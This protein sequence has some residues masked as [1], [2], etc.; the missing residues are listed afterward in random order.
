MT[1]ATVK[2][3]ARKLHPSIFSWLDFG[4]ARRREQ[5]GE[6]GCD[7]DRWVQNP[8]YPACSFCLQVDAVTT[9]WVALVATAKISQ[10]GLVHGSIRVRLR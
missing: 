4:S 5:G 2:P 8:P 6:F 10:H 9:R 7:L 1:K 3:L